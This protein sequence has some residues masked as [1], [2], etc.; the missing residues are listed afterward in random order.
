MVQSLGCEAFVQFVTKN[1][2]SYLDGSQERYDFIFLD[3]NHSAATVYQEI[4][5][6]LNILK[7]PGLILLHDYFPGNRP[8]WSNGLVIPGPYTAVARLRKEDPTINVIPLGDLPWST[9]LNSRTTSLAL[10]TRHE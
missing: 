2:L 1:S 6:A 7:R 4:P 3:G 8:L 9:K 10:I 5:R